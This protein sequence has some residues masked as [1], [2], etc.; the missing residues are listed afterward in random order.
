MPSASPALSSAS[1]LFGN[2]YRAPT[3]SDEIGRSPSRLSQHYSLATKRTEK[4]SLPTV[5]SDAP[6]SL[7][8]S[9]IRRNS[10]TKYSVS[11]ISKFVIGR[12]LISLE[13]SRCARFE[14][15]VCTNG[16]VSVALFDTF[17]L[18]RELNKLKEE[19][20][21]LRQ[22]QVELE[23]MRRAIEGRQIQ[24]E[25]EEND[26]RQ[27]NKEKSPRRSQR[28]QDDTDPDMER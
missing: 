27:A 5:S 18:S 13:R 1:Y 17:L 9:P 14:K 28:R 21:R 24:S 11:T 2:R 10:W 7:Q 4:R 12:R 20:E 6:S 16:C 22:R 8:F 3:S 25:R 23:R 19:Q 26:R 15:Q